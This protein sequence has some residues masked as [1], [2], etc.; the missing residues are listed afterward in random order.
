[1]KIRIYEIAKELQI[2]SNII[3]G[4]LTQDNGKE[5]TPFSLISEAEYLKAKQTIANGAPINYHKYGSIIHERITGNEVLLQQLKESLKPME[6]IFND[7][8]GFY[9]KPHEATLVVKTLLSEPVFSAMRKVYD[10]Q[11]LCYPI[12]LGLSSDEENIVRDFTNY[13]FQRIENTVAAQKSRDGQVIIALRTLQTSIVHKSIKVSLILADWLTKWAGYLQR[14]DTFSPTSLKSYKQREVIL[15][16]FGFNVGSEFGGRHYAVVLEKNNNPRS[17]VI[18]V[19]P[20][21]SYDQN[22][23][24][25]AHKTNVDLGIGAINNYTKGAQ[26]VMNQVRYISKLRIEKP[27]TSYENAIY[28]EK[29]KFAEIYKKLNKRLMP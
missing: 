10:M 23:G 19:A 29:D 13:F 2:T 28:I 14:E 21:S 27:K 7:L 16:D 5:L 25:R 26:V 3:I 20:I 18:L 15:V 8:P 4:I 9:N 11:F 1:M 12:D 17:N 6:S 22:N 24:Q